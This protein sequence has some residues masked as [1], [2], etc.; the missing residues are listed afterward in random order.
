M[1]ELTNE[2]LAEIEKRHADCEAFYAGHG[3]YRPDWH[4]DRAALLAKLRARTSQAEAP[5]DARKDEIEIAKHILGLIFPK[6]NDADF[7]GFV[8]R[9]GVHIAAIIRADRNAAP[10][11]DIDVIW[12][13]LKAFQ[14]R[15]TDKEPQ[16]LYVRVSYG[17]LRAALRTSQAEAQAPTTVAQAS[18]TEDEP[19]IDWLIDTVAHC[20]TGHFDSV[21][22]RN[23]CDNKGIIDRLT[24]G[25]PA[26]TTAAQASVLTEDE[27]A[28]W[29]ALCYEVLGTTS[30]DESLI[31][32]CCKSTKLAALLLRFIEPTSTV[33]APAPA[34]APKHAPNCGY[35]L[36]L[37]C[38]CKLEDNT[39]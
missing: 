21:M 34:T 13:R 6:A 4:K 11:M 8:E 33:G 38:S 5:E 29:K 16:S 25:A 15:D 2:E 12:A 27:R 26:P 37:N 17:A 24:V 36:D 35:W 30:T 22:F 14:P 3:G 23:A 1:T 7:K 31:Y 19:L 32:W 20:T 9:H 28:E 18:V 10:L 39:P